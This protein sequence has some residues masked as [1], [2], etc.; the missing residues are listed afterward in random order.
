MNPKTIRIRELWKDLAKDET[1]S[2]IEARRNG[3]LVN[4]GLV[5]HFRLHDFIPNKWFDWE[6]RVDAPIMI[7][8]QD[9]GPYVEIKKF[10][11]DYN[12]YK[13][14]KDFDYEEF[15]YK[16]FSSRTEKFIFKAIE[17]TYP[18]EKKSSLEFSKYFFFTVAVLFTRKGIHFRGNHNFDPKKSAEHS[19]QYFKRQL[20]IVRPSVVMPLGSLALYQTE[21]YFDLNLKGANLTQKINNLDKGV[22]HKAQSTIIPNYH[23]AAYVNPDLMMT[24]WSKIW[25]YVDL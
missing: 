1:Y 12:H 16:T 2:K 14:R 4:V 15:L 11:D 9:W 25:D 24:I 21:K 13:D 18:K 19:Y 6:R 5:N 7:I 17:E 23:P 22:I 20:D 8:G 3:K 10:V